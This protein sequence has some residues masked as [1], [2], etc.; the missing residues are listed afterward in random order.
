MHVRAR[1]QIGRFDEVC[2]GAITHGIRQEDKICSALEFISFYMR[3]ASEGLEHGLNA[4]FR[5]LHHPTLSRGLQKKW[6]ITFSARI[7]LHPN[8]FFLLCTCTY[9]VN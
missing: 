4:Y 3:S 1:Y 7:K 5:R 8:N 6:H 2:V 9:I